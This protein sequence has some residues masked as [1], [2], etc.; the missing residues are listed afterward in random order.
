MLLLLLLILMLLLQ[1]YASAATANLVEPTRF[2]FDGPVTSPVSFSAHT[3]M[4][5]NHMLHGP[6]EGEP[7]GPVEGVGAVG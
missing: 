6:G 7:V 5:R 3:K 4:V 2:T 1:L